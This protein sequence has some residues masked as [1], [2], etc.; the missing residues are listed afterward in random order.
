MISK[1]E[2]E[3]L[4]NLHKEQ[5][6]LEERIKALEYKPQQIVTDS[7]KG[8]SKHFPYIKHNCIVQG[9]ENDSNYKKRKNIIKKL[10]KIYNGN[11]INIDKK[12]LHIEYEL[13]K[14]ED[15]EIRQIIRYKYEDNL[16]WIQIM[17]RRGDTSE[18]VARKKLE[19]FL[20]K[21]K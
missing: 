10:K 4:E 3:Q 12:I 9:L 21:I 16:S 6:D 1:K 8:S 13:K 18:D 2:L 7:V 14:I 20:E 15:T 5:I 19:R 17:H 11:K